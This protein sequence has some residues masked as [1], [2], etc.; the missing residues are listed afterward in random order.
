[1]KY[2]FTSIFFFFSFCYTSAQE[3]KKGNAK[4]LC[5]YTHSF[6]PWQNDTSR[7]EG[8]FILSLNE[9]YSEYQSI[10]NFNKGIVLDKGGLN[11]NEI[12]TQVSAFT[13]LARVIHEMPDA[14]TNDIIIRKDQQNKN[15]YV[16][17]GY[18][19]VTRNLFIESLNELEWNVTD[20]IRLIHDFKC[21]KALSEYGDYTII[22]WFAPEIPFSDGSYTFGGLPGLILELYD[23]QRLHH[24]TIHKVDNNPSLLLVDRWQNSAG[25]FGIKTSKK[26]I[27]EIGKKRKLVELGYNLEDDQLSRFFG[28]P[29]SPYPLIEDFT[30]EKKDELLI[31]YSLY[32]N[33]LFKFYKLE[34][35]Q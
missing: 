32:D 20:E 7:I 23:E 9:K 29:T 31:K 24:F 33:L 8:E 13:S 4:L 22:A 34:K 16:N 6:Q 1:M 17:H 21:Y 25:K 2:Y 14:K 28:Q 30:S 3:G 35:I 18:L 5:Y 11:G 10:Q 27:K 12:S 26:I 19:F 15:V